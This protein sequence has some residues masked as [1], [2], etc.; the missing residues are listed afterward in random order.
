MADKM[1]DIEEHRVSVKVEDRSGTG[2]TFAD[3]DGVEVIDGFLYV[4]KG[5]DTVAVYAAGQWI[6]ADITKADA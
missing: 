3:A 1:A 4:E 6:H 5:Q 2:T